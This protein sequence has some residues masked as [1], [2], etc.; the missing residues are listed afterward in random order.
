MVKLNLTR[1][2]RED[3]QALS[4]PPGAVALEVG[5]AVTLKSQHWQQQRFGFR[6]HCTS[7]KGQLYLCSI[8]SGTLADFSDF[9]GEGRELDNKAFAHNLF[10]SEVAHV[11]S[12]TLYWLKQVPWSGLMSMGWK[13]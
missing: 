7:I 11:T 3:G 5:R 6:S 4:L 13:I 10:C 1:H 2:Q 8:L 9:M 12:V